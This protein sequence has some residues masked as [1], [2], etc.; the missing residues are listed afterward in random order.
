MKKFLLRSAIVSILGLTVAVQVQARS[1]GAAGLINFMGSVTTDSCVLRDN[2]AVRTSG[3][4][5]Y[6]MGSVSVHALGTEA[7][8]TTSAGGSITALPVDMNMQLEC[9]EG[10]AV[11][12]TLT[13]AIASGKGIGL[14]GGVQNV[15]IMLMN[16]SE[17]VDFSGGS[18]TINASMT[19]GKANI[20]M[21]AYYTLVAGRAA[22]NVRAGTANGTVGYMMS[23]H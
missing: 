17:P 6:S 21:K 20:H 19:R 2:N 12:L 4:M 22:S 1:F 8:P 13:P 5:T 16:G 23:Y 10:V 7:A 9:L 15:Q 3:G 18:Q 14:T 11:E